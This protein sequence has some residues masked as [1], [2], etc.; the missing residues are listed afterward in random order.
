MSKLFKL[1]QQLPLIAILRGVAPKDVIRITEILIEAGFTMIEIPLNSPDALISIK[2]LVE[3]FG[4]DY[5]IGAGTVTTLKQAEEVIATGANLIVTPNFNEQVVQAGAQAGCATFP[6][7]VTPT[8]AFSA[9]AA[10]ATGIKIFPISALGM[11]GFK[12]LM[13]V[14]PPNTLC[15]PVGGINPTIESLKPLMELGAKG[16]GLG[17][18]LYSP[19][20]S[21]ET[22]KENAQLFVQ[23][24]QGSLAV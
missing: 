13:S 5:F 22:I 6:G 21:D 18:S 17:A 20:M 16:F 8:E 15:F 14:L 7:I 19:N 12:A 1:E 10:G 4:K 9:L 2:R 23:A 11:S 3:R 24:Y